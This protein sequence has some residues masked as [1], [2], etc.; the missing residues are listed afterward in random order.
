MKC[1]KC[2]R[3]ITDNS[4]FCNWCGAKQIKDGNVSVPKPTRLASGEYVGRI[5]VGGRRE[6]V[7]GNTEADYYKKARAVKEELVVLKETPSKLKLNDVIEDFISKNTPILS[8][9]TIRAYTYYQKQLLKYIDKPVNVI[10]WQ[11]L[12]N[13][14]AKDYKP[15]TVKN[16]WGLIT[17]SLKAKDI[18]VPNVR[19]PAVQKTE[20]TFLEPKE[21]PRLLQ[22]VKDKPIELTV[23][24]GLHSLRESEILAITKDSIQNGIIHVKGAVVRNKDGEYIRKEENKTVNSQRDI[25][26]F[27]PRLTELWNSL[28]C[29][30][31][32]PNP[33]NM[34][35]DL[36]RLC[37][38][39]AI[40]PISPHGL[41][42]TFCSLAYYLNW[43]IKTTQLIGGW[44]SPRVPTEIY[45]HLSQEKQAKDIKA[46]KK[47]YKK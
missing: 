43:D 27:I 23:L 10:D 2:K 6:R 36:L 18:P 8:P 28:E 35:R 15:K 34:R 32:W 4:I 16:Q 17:G 3:E 37:K 38:N 46:I 11:D 30:P 19:L 33:S 24:L 25:P 12:I 22:A 13:R 1:R 40:T 42:H 21:I 5:M 39:N 45:T 47:F 9:S 26:V 14:L 44:S 7:K 31:Q 41:R 29:D 20:R